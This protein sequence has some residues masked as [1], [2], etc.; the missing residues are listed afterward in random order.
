MSTKALQDITVLDLSKVLAGPYCGGMLADF[1]ANVIKIEP[2]V[3]GE[4]ARGYGPHKNGESL[5]YA[6]LNRGKK[7][8]TL[9]LKT[10]EAK[11][12][13]K[14]LVKDA[15]V[16]IENYRP[17]TMD[18]FGLGY[19]ELKKI[20]PRL[21]YGV[22][23]GFGKT[24]PYASRPGYDIISQAMGGLMSITGQEGN[25][26]T[27]A[28][29]AM[30]DVLGGMNLCIGILAAIHARELTGKGQYIDIA[31]T[32]S[33]IASLE[34]A[35]QRFFVSG[36]LPTRHGNSYDAIAPYDSFKAKDGYVVIGCGN[37]KLFEIFCKELLQRPELIEDGRFLNVPLR[38][39]N[40]KEFKVYVE[41]WLSGVNVDEA[42][43]LVLSKGIPAGP[44]LDLRQ[45]SEDEHFCNYRK[46]FTEV[47]HPVAG[48][49]KLNSNPIHLSE[50]KVKIQGPSPS[51]G[52]HNEEVLL[53]LGY[54]EEDISYFSEK[55]II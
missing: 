26:P 25:P 38:V 36:N 18:K 4:D 9:N 34:Q 23:T 44:I 15:D 47:N 54:S 43:K 51:L 19:E 48:T 45:I 46:V 22:I 40:N 42:V 29:S 30:A 32:D 20:N 39:K 12:I 49:I 31:L 53:G 37:Q 52:Q 8:I 3:K 33:V 7:G 6:N 50:T 5:Y 14:K 2:P 17:G 41:E 13:F 27:R 35:W 11:E 1:G 10:L 28:G 16:V 55:G 21:I 24:G